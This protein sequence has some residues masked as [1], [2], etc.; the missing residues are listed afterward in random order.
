MAILAALMARQH[1][2]KG[3][4]VD[5]AMSDGVAYMLASLM[6]EYFATGVVPTRG[7]MSLNGGTPYYNVYM[8]RDGGYISVGC[9]EPWFW[10]TLCRALGREDLI[11][12]QFEPK[13]ATF[14]KRELDEVFK[15]RDRDEWWDL[16]SAIDNIAV[17]KVNS[18]DEAVADI[19]NI[20]RDMVVE[21]GE[22][23]GQPIRQVGIGPKLS[24]TPGSI[25]SLGATIG[26][27]TD[28]ILAELGYSAKQI[29]EM[30]AAGAVG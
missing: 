18:L 17:A 4:Y 26:Q 15:T 27:H 20:H 3:Q 6:S 30:R 25:R 22:V 9:I 16:L 2:G 12:G 19:Q 13:R 8:C 24:E 28:E 21:A 1:T 7:D 5:I 11:E 23:D 29:S 10:S 14:V